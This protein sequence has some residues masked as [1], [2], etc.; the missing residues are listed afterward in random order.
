MRSRLHPARR[1]RHAL[2]TQA[3]RETAS[4]LVALTAWTLASAASGQ[5]VQ[6]Q[7]GDH[8]DRR[9]D[10]DDG[11]GGGGYNH[12]AILA[13]S[14]RVETA[15]DYGQG[16]TTSPSSRRSGRHEAGATPS[17]LGCRLP[18]QTTP[19][20]PP[21]TK[22]RRFDRRNWA[23]RTSVVKGGVFSI[24]VWIIII[25]IVLALLGFFARGRR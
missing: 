18:D 23:K 1:V 17:Q 25:V 24:I 3:K 13:S 10:S 4:R 9:R 20:P 2:E 7:E 16:L 19:T 8:D 12:T 5:D 6:D 14:C 15:P 22:A 21:W 11:D